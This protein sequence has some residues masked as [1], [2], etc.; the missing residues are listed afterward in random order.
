[1]VYVGME[2]A[3]FRCPTMD[4]IIYLS[5]R[6]ASGG[7]SYW[8]DYKWD[9]YTNRVDG[10]GNFWCSHTVFGYDLNNEMDH[11]WCETPIRVNALAMI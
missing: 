4:D 8:L 2:E 7:I 5:P 10:D 6:S 1:M 9:Y 3:I 11:C